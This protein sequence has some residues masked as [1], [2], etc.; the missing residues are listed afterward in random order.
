MG[1]IKINLLGRQRLE[2]VERQNRV[3][4]L[5]R[6][7]YP[8]IGLSVVFVVVCV[9]FFVW[10]NSADNDMQDQLRQVARK[11]NDYQDLAEKN[12]VVAERLQAIGEIIEGRDI[13]NEKI[14]VFTLVREY[15]L[16]LRS[17]DFGGIENKYELTFSGTSSSIDE[18]IKFNEYLVELAQNEGIEKIEVGNLVRGDDGVYRFE[19][20]LEFNRNVMDEDNG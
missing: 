9:G 7:F 11:L 3:A 17:V 14:K 4:R 13:F 8:M 19:Y 12:Y 5:L 2:I 1:L 15:G 16:D 18:Y 6:F 10:L 20:S